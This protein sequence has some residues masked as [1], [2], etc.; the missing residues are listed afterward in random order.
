[1]TGALDAGDAV[2]IGVVAVADVGDD[3]VGVNGV[4]VS[5]VVIQRELINVI[6]FR[7]HL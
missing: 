6:H 1:M 7:L 4:G 2:V 3:G 5:G